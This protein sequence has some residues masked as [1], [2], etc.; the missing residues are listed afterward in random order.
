MVFFSDVNFTS[1]VP[2]QLLVSDMITEKIDGNSMT[3]LG[4]DVSLVDI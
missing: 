1:T 3:S 4:L 2:P